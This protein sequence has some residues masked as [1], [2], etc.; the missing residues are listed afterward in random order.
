MSQYYAFQMTAF[1]NGILLFTLLDIIFHAPTFGTHVN[2]ASAHKNTKLVTTF[3]EGCKTIA[4]LLNT[5][6]Y[7]P[8]HH[9][10]KK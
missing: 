4:H 8:K 2:Q 10:D 7:P 6:Q 3:S 5:Q 9:L 1:Q